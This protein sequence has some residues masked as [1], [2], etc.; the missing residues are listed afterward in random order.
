L[1]L[2]KGLTPDR[3]KRRMS[4]LKDL[5]K[6]EGSAEGKLIESWTAD[7][8]Q[9]FTLLSS[10]EG[11]AAFDLSNEAEQMRGRYGFTAFG[12][13]CLLARRLAE[14]GVPYIQVNWSE[15]VEPYFGDKTDYGWDTHK[16]NFE[17]LNDRHCPIL[18][19]AMSGLLDDLEQRGLLETTM[20]VAM[21]EFG[22]TP[23]IDGSYSRGHWNNAY[24]SLWCGAGVKK[25]AVV[26]ATNDKAETP[27]TTPIY[28][29]SV[30][31]T[32]LHL[33][34]ITT[35]KRAQFRVLPTAKVIDCLFA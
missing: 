21:G 29:D 24:S 4:L 5:D 20:V 22:R 11:R 25:G 30:G 14:V 17:L 34:G 12:Q 33:V 3:L 28:P 23:R 26:G 35:E 31:A 15:Y 8:K 2:L 10:K 7:Q 9:A 18:D 32:L 13:G 1:D 19:H 27:I 6:F 16:N